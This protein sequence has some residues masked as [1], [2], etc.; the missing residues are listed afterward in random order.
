[1]ID[2]DTLQLDCDLSIENQLRAQLAAAIADNQ[3]LTKEVSR[4]KA[5]SRQWERRAHINR[6]APAE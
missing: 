2:H 3:A 4:W 1:M 5:N 6:K